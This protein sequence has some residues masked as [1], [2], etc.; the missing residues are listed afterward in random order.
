[1]K[2]VTSIQ[3]TIIGLCLTQLTQAQ[4]GSLDVTFNTGTGANATVFGVTLQTN[5]QVIACGRFTTF[6]SLIRHYIARLNSDGSVDPSFD[7]GTGPNSAV[8]GLAIQPDGKVLIWGQFTFVN[9]LPYLGLARLR[10]DGSVDTGFTNLFV[11]IYALALQSNGRILISGNLSQTNCIAR[12]TTNGTLDATFK[13]AGVFSSYGDYADSFG[14]Q[15]NG[16]IIIGGGFTKIN[17]VSLNSLARLNA[18]GSLDTSFNAQVGLTGASSVLCLAVTP[19]DKI[20]IGGNFNSVNGYSR[21]GIAR[22][23]ADGSVDTTF[24][25]GL[26]AS[27]G[28]GFTAVQALAVQ[29]SGRVLIGGSFTA[30]NGTN[31]IN[32]ARLNTDGSLDLAFD[33][34]TGTAN[35]VFS[36]AGQPNEKTLV[37]CVGGVFGAIQMNGIARLNGDNS[38]T[39]VL[40]LLTPSRFFG[41]YLQ[42]TVGDTYR[43]EW[44]SDLNT[45]SLWTPLF[46]VT[47]Q[48][49]PQLVVDPTSTSGQRFYRAVQLSP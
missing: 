22:L 4:P 15:S 14:L 26:G 2:L 19:D 20:I 18:D 36:L 33:A 43:L 9:S 8:S 13:P 37:G 16:Q 39:N 10:G 23:N 11:A 34:S 3:V 30:F 35:T 41:T 31:S 6:N 48:T 45:P 40:Q 47:L 38:P 1:M 5:G 32:V 44:T 28:N 27:G 7:P 12:V 42:G 29:A 17:G 21:N 25:P 46:N 24:N 49:N